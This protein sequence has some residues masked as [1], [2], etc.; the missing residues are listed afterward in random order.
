M[1]RGSSKASGGNAVNIGGNISSSDAVT[2]VSQWIDLENV[3][4]AT[5]ALNKFGKYM[6]PV[7]ASRLIKKIE[8]LRR[9]A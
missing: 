5:K 6:S 4:E 3:Q 1:G 7:Q 9:R 2:L 8:K